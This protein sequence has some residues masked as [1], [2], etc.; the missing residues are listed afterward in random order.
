MACGHKPFASLTDA[1]VSAEGRCW[2]QGFRVL[3]T[4]RGDPRVPREWRPLL[5]FAILFLL[6]KLRS[7]A[8]R[9]LNYPFHV[10]FHVGRRN[11]PRVCRPGVLQVRD[12][13]CSTT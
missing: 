12:G 6:A 5:R 3:L 2:R 13:V 9:Y 4:V 7:V 8:L 1:G 11:E 10:V